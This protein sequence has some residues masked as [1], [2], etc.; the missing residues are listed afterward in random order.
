M[1]DRTL[2]REEISRL[3]PHGEAMVLIDRVVSADDRSILCT[4]DSHRRLDHPLL[5]ADG[6]LHAVAGGEYGAQAAAIHGALRS[7]KPMPPGMIVLVRELS[8]SRRSLVDIAGTLQVEAT[9]LH[10]GAAGLVYSFAL[11]SAGETIVAGEV[12]IILK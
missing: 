2:D 7:G 9:A 6:S 3:V 8:W 12:G 11:S 5:G 1:L 10:D 4:T